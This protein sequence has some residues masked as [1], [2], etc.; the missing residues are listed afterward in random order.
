M[1]LFQCRYVQINS[2]LFFLYNTFRFSLSNMVILIDVYGYACSYKTSS[3]NCFARCGANLLFKIVYKYTMAR[4]S[5]VLFPKSYIT[6]FC[7]LEDYSSFSSLLHFTRQVH[8]SILLQDFKRCFRSFYI[9]GIV[10]TIVRNYPLKIGQLDFT[11]F[12]C[13]KRSSAKLI[14]LFKT[15]K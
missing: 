12:N 4:E 13:V 3:F 14:S 9:S 1:L 6:L 2:T 5:E 8:H 15:R 11:F 7:N 10:F